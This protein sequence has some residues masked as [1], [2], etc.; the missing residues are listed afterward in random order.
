[1][2]LIIG[3]EVI[4]LGY[5]QSRSQA[6]Q[7]TKPLLAIVH[8]SDDRKC[9][10]RQRDCWFLSATHTEGM[11]TGVLTCLLKWVDP[12]ICTGTYS[13][14]LLRTEATA[15]GQS[16]PNKEHHPRSLLHQIYW[17]SKQT[18]QT[19]RVHGRHIS[20]WKENRCPILLEWFTCS[21]KGKAFSCFRDRRSPTVRIATTASDYR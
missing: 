10:Y 4:V 14:H 18:S 1:M 16:P 19:G 15:I 11:Y 20:R 9:R 6:Y 8:R 13:G 21:R 12:N 7:S 2:H 3:T 5:S 17:I